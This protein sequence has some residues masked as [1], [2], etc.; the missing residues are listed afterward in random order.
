MEHVLIADDDVGLLALIAETLASDSYE[1]L[2]ASDG[3]QAWHILRRYRPRVAI[4]D[5]QMPGRT[6][7]DLVRAVRAEPA[8]AATKI[9]LLT[10]QALKADLE[11]GREAG[12]DRYLTKPFSPLELVTTVERM[13]DTR[14]DLAPAASPDLS[15]SW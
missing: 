8:L 15:S 10:A 2:L 3:D 11:A 1:T 9:I 14:P 4:L 5:V 6:G 7:I 13:L 12:A